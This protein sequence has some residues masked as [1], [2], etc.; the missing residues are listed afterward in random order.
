MEIGHRIR[1]HNVT[2][3]TKQLLHTDIC[4]VL[5]Q[6]NAKFALDI[7]HL[8]ELLHRYTYATV[9]KRPEGVSTIEWVEQLGQELILH[10][11]HCVEQLPEKK[12]HQL[13]SGER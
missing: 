2:Y 5:I 12:Q 4:H 13:L 11:Q 1:I 8:K 10:T 3:I 7:Q 9:E 6:R